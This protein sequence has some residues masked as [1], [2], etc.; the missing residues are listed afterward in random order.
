[1]IWSFRDYKGRRTLHID[2]SDN[3]NLYS[4]AGVSVV[5]DTGD[6]K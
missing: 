4:I 6:K 1:M 5:H 3:T 2:T